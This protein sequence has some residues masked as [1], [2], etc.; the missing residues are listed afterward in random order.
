MCPLLVM[1][2]THIFTPTVFSL[3]HEGHGVKTGGLV[4]SES[5]SLVYFL[6]VSA[7]VSH[8]A[9]CTSKSTIVTCAELDSPG[10][11]RLIWVL[12]FVLEENHSPR[13]G[14]AAR[15]PESLCICATISTLVGV[16]RVE[17]RTQ[18]THRCITMT[19]HKLLLF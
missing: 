4:H 16:G 11:A 17:C 2:R 7:T 18:Y 19:S 5:N 3:Q 15:I 1:V 10:H 8:A 9:L 13:S 14:K 6:R 12:Y